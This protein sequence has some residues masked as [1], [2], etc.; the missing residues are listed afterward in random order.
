LEIISFNLSLILLQAQNYLVAVLIP[1][2]QY[3]LYYYLK[4]KTK[5]L[6][7]LDINDCRGNGG[8]P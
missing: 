8:I 5:V 2:L 6:I 1:D 7:V 4:E 3:I